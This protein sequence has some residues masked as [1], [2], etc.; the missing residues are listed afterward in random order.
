[1]THN[2]QPAAR[3]SDT[4]TYFYLGTMVEHGRT[5]QMFT[6]P[7]QEQTEAYVTGRFG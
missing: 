2:L 3:V 4:T 7:V 6:A 5:K 1:V